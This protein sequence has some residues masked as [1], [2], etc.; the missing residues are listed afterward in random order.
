MHAIE[1]SDYKAAI[2]MLGVHA[3][4]NEENLISAVISKFQNELD[5]L[6]RRYTSAPVNL[7]ESLEKRIKDTKDKIK[8]IEDRIKSTD[9]CPIGFCEF[10][11][12]SVRA[13]VPCCQN[14][15]L[16]ENILTALQRSSACPFCRQSISPNKLCIINPMGSNDNESGASSSNTQIL[17]IEDKIY[18]SCEEGFTAVVK[19]IVS[20]NADAKILIFSQFD[21][22]NYETILNRENIKCK[23]IQ[24]SSD[25]ISCTL[26]KFSNG[27]VQALMMNANHFGAGINLQM[28]DHIIVVHRLT[29]DRYTQLVGRG[30]RP[31]RTG[32]LTVWNLQYC[33]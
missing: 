19:Q 15:F 22:F 14:V 8:S 12:E 27:D 20:T 9:C 4:A 26:N 7:L 21:M 24:G 3:V 23:V 10:T 31:G 16:L 18:S 30:Q 29:H 25:Q 5:E 17:S 28:A 1:A 6:E 13:V 33:Q 2:S 11:S 32:N